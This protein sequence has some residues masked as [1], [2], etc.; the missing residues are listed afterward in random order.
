[1]GVSRVPKVLRVP[2]LRCHRLLLAAVAMVLFLAACS[3]PATD[4]AG[5]NQD[6]STDVPATGSDDADD[7]GN[8]DTDDAD[9]STA[10]APAAPGESNAPADTGTTAAPATP[11]PSDDGSI[12]WQHRGEPW[13][14][15][16]IPSAAVAADMSA[17]PI[18]IGMI[19]QE[20]TPIGSFPEVR[21]AA[22]AAI[23][24]INAEL[25][26]VDG[27]PLEFHWCITPFSPEQSQVC[28]QE[29]VQEGVVALVG[30]INVMSQAAFPILEQNGIPVVGGIPAGLTEQR[31][32]SSF[33][34]SG[35]S[36]GGLAAFMK[37]AADNGADKAVIAYGE[38]DAF[39]VAAADYGAVVGE[40]LGLDVKLVRFPV[41]AA[42]FLPVLNQA[43]EFEADAVVIAAADSSCVSIMKTFKELEI[44]AQLYLVG[45]CAADHVIEAADG[46]NIGVVFNSEG[47][48]NDADVE[49][50][51]FD[52]ATNRYNT[53]PAQAAGTVGF[54]G[55]MNLYGVLV[56]LGGDHIT[57]EAIID[58]LRQSVDHESFWGHPYTCDGQQ[59]PGLPAL[60]APQQTLFKMESV[61]EVEYVSG[62]I[63]TAEL[64][65][66]SGAGQ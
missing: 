3:E 6:D 11:G 19:N 27:R 9:A 20:D 57:S 40:Y 66:A 39:E 7:T 16:T 32:A 59:V 4:D 33:T 44:D 15:G 18:K 43:I 62:W 52:E 35:G 2:E 28:A 17:E 54:R 31:S 34:F 38:F 56:E 29:M 49:G 36:S 30:G 60:C 46:A 24:W 23:N 12:V 10:A 45:A 22:E 58:Q 37:H 53:G 42:D 25:G 51:L 65:A 1:M 64:F 47:P 63:D 5:N 8:E 55:M 14:L 13:F 50:T 26:G 48:P 61:G 21:F 41:I